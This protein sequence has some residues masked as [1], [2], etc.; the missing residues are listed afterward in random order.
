MAVVPTLLGL[1]LSG[2]GCKLL[3]RS[4]KVFDLVFEMGLR[5][6]R[7]WCRGSVGRVL[8][9]GAYQWICIDFCFPL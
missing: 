6:A 5:R 9:G 1:L 8:F 7:V 2:R 3:F 4:G